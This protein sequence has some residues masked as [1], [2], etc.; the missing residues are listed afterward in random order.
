HRDD[1]QVRMGAQGRGEHPGHRPGPQVLVL[2]VDQAPGPGQRLPVGVRD[3]ALAMRGE[4]V[5]AQPGR[6]GT[7]HLD[8]VWAAYRAIVGHRL[9]ERAAGHR[10]HVV[11]PVVQLADRAGQVQHAA[12][13]PPLTER[14]L[15]VVHGRAAYLRLD[16]MPRRPRAVA[17]RELHH[18]RVAAVPG[19]VVAAVP[20]VDAADEGAVPTG[21]ARVPEHHQL[22]VVAAAPPG[23]G[24][25][26]DLAAV[27]VY[28]PDEIR[29]GFLGLV[30]RPG[31]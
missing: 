16:V 21:G 29:V 28:L 22:L 2:Q 19:V 1:V 23:P 7:Q 24:V 8:R 5:A 20:E 10:A 18:L 13:V 31:L 25:Q 12:A 15:Q 30:Q 6:V 11:S 4:R 26:Q 17:V 3:A 14:V 27:L 9:G